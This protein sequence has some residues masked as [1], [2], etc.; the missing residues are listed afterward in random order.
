MRWRFEDDV[1]LSNGYSVV[2]YPK[3][4]S[5]E[6]LKGVELTWSDDKWRYIHRIGPLRNKLGRDRKRSFGMVETTVLEEGVRQTYLEP[7]EE[8]DKGKVIGVDRV[9]ELLWLF[10]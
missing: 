8:D 2:E 7:A 3:G 10:D 6:E 1:V 5:D 9:V 4:I